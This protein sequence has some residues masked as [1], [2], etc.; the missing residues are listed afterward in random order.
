[1]RNAT[2]TAIAPTGTI[3]ILAGTT[4][5]IEP[6]FALAYRRT[7]VLGEQTMLEVTP[8]L[9]EYAE[10]RGFAPDFPSQGAGVGAESLL[11]RLPRSARQ[12]FAT[13]LT[14]PAERHLEIQAAFQ[15]HTDNSVSKTVNLPHDASAADVALIY[16]CAWERELNGVT[17]YRYGSRSAQVLELAV[18][19]EPYQYDHATACDPTECRV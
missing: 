2:V 17:I 3:S 9:R 16:Q 15:R 13:A 6:L 18:A 12:L 19:E 5:S 11:S 14:I 8:L 7:H 1:V 4:A 10:L